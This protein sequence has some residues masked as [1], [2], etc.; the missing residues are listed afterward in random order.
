MTKQNQIEDIKKI[1]QK[2]L[3]PFEEFIALESVSTQNRHLLETAE[4]MVNMLKFRW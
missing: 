3:T 2:N 1:V 4:Y